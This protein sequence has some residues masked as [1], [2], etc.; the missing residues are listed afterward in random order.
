V[1]QKE[2]VGRSAIDNLE[3]VMIEWDEKT[4]DAKL[5]ATVPLH[6][7]KNKYNF[8]ARAAVLALALGT[9]FALNTTAIAQAPPGSLW[10]NG[11]FNGVGFHANGVNTS[12]PP[13]AVYGEFNVPAGPFWHV[14][15]IFSDNLLSTVVTGAEWE[16]R[17]GLSVGNFGHLVA[18]GSTQTPVITPTGRSGFGLNE[19]TVEVTGLNINLPAD[20][21][22]LNVEPIGNG[23]G[24]SLNTTT[25]GTN[26]VGAPCGN[27]MSFLL[28]EGIFTTTNFSMGVIGQSVPEPATWALLGGGL[29]A[30]LIAARRR[31]S[32]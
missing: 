25:T 31:R 1:Q 10:Y 4:H 8:A 14:T 11:D 13:S 28:P 5:E 32:V 21:Y 16:I 29:G 12:D 22:W 24:R 6:P 30:L 23:T 18:S 19:F 20:T 17:T 7:M 15:T 3:A 27:G 9:A 26:C 2:K